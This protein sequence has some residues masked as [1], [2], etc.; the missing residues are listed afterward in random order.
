MNL[1]AKKIFILLVG[2][3]IVLCLSGCSKSVPIMAALVPQAVGSEQ[4]IGE[5]NGEQYIA[6]Q[7]DEYNISA[8]LYGKVSMF[9]LALRI[10]NKTDNT[11]G[12]AEYSVG[13]Y[14][15][16]DHKP[17]KIIDRDKVIVYR[18]KLASGGSLKTG[19]SMVDYS[20][21]QITGLF[22]SMTRSEASVYLSYIDW[23]V[24]NYYS[25]RP[26]YAHEA[27]EGIL[28]AETDFMP[29]YPIVIVVKIG[30]KD[31]QFR[32]VPPA[33]EKNNAKS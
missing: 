10:E 20:M 12:T 33:E 30:N 16:R 15:G 8:H 29:E 1:N 2:F 24:N 5:Q 31:I 23:A 4:T 17:L 3:E 27:R 7:S 6:Y 26:I 13:V 14:D 21:G 28:V 25:F 11:I 22:Q 18:N 9:G 32:F 19:N